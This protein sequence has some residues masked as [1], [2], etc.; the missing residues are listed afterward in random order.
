MGELPRNAKN[1]QK[2]ANNLNAVSCKSSWIFVCQMFEWHRI[3]LRTLVVRYWKWVIPKS[4]KSCWTVG[5]D[6]L[7]HPWHETEDDV[8]ASSPSLSVWQ[9]LNLLLK[10]THVLK[11]NC[12][13]LWTDWS[14]HISDYTRLH[15]IWIQEIFDLFYMLDQNAC[16]I[17]SKSFQRLILAI[18]FLFGPD[19]CM[20]LQAFLWEEITFLFIRRKNYTLWNTLLFG[21]R[22][23]A[24][25][26]LSLGS[27]TIPL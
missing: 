2:K 4:E 25:E 27:T 11:N 8:T 26:S 24:R 22:S 16:C 7:F 17:P 18:K 23:F 5:W 12:V 6:K 14:V 10:W 3:E 1:G 19:L 15:C 9:L 20:L 13:T 21:P